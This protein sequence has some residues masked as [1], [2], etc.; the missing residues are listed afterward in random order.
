MKQGEDTAN[1]LVCIYAFDSAP[2]SLS[3]LMFSFFISQMKK[4]KE[5]KRE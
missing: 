1:N 2:H 4:E 3:P 5:K